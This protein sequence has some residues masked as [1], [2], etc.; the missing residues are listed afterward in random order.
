MGRFALA[1]TLL[2]LLLICSAIAQEGEKKFVPLFDGKTLDGWAVKGGKCTYR[3]EDGMI[4]GKTVEGS[5][6]T[7]LCTTKDYGDFEFIC[8]VK[9]DPPLNS[10]IQIRSHV[11]EKDTFP[12]GDKNKKKK[13][14]PAGTVFGYQVEIADNG[15]AGRIWDEARHTKWHDPEP[16]DKTKAAYKPTEWN[17]F[18]ILAE[19]DRIRTW[20]NGVPIVDIRDK[21][22]KTGFFGLQVHSIKAGTGPYE[23]RWKNIRIREIK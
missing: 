10:G 6:N 16:T 14:R 23:V 17:N 8:D 15:N 9:C 20:I 12:P 4:V 7:F 11:Y 1:S 19:G 3:V 5:S 18:R 22:D 21:E 2:A 13:P